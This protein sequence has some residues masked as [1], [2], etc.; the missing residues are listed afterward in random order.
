MTDLATPAIAEL[1]AWHA[2]QNPLGKRS[3]CPLWCQP[4]QQVPQAAAYLV[5]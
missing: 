3:A 4:P 1:H 2:E 5:S